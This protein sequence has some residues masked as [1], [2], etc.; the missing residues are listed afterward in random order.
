MINAKPQILI[1][2]DEPAICDL[3]E[4]DLTEHGYVC[5]A[6]LDGREAVAKL[7]KEEF[8]IVLLDIKMPR[9]SGLEVL[10]RIRADGH[11]T[12]VIMITC[13]NSIDTVATALKLGACDYIIKPFDLDEVSSNI[14]RL[15]ETKKHLPKEEGHQ[16]SMY[17]GREEETRRFKRED[18]VSL[19]TNQEPSSLAQEEVS[20]G[21]D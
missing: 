14:R 10:K 3:L 8:D 19:Q 4:D 17:I 11:S 5:T 20:Y 13:V 6:A 16:A 18:I 15:L 2:D 12:A 21:E 9:M 7:E 1:V